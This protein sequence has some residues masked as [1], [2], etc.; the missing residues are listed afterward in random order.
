MQ[1][2][3]DHIDPDTPALRLVG[4]S[5]D[6]DA[7]AELFLG[8]EGHSLK[9]NRNPRPDAAM[10]PDS[11]I[12]DRPEVVVRPLTASTNPPASP[13]HGPPTA[14]THPKAEAETAQTVSVEALILGHLPVRSV[15]WIGQYA[16]A[17]AEKLGRP[18]ALLRLG[19][20]DASLDLHGMPLGAPTPAGADT[21]EEAIERAQAV[22]R[23]WIIQVDELSESALAADDRLDAITLLTSANETAV[24]AAYRAIKG[25]VSAEDQGEPASRPGFD[26]RAGESDSPAMR[27]AI[28]GAG[29][30]E[31]GVALTRLRHACSVFLGR[32]L[33]LAATVAKVSPARGVSL[34]RG[35]AYDLPSILELLAPPSSTQLPSHAVNSVASAHAVLTAQASPHEMTGRPHASDLGDAGR[36]LAGHLPGLRAL[37]TRCPDDPAIEL[38]IDAD[39]RLNLLRRADAPDACQRMVA[40]LAWAKRHADLLA[41]AAAS[42]GTLDPARPPLGR[43]FTSEPPALRPLLDTDIRLHL[44]AQA[45]PD[46]PW[47]CVELN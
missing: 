4:V 13:P 45:T 11:Q 19:A 14:T 10:T 46:T 41:L 17:R 21:L 12:Q 40:A 20:T 24:I 34:F 39:G 1:G 29:E 5:D 28:M 9:G 44:L 8:S 38:A 22:T 16:R 18:M 26:P 35:P 23:D 6:Y 27:V 15:V 42:V 2:A 47:L 31:A 36:P 37:P 33:E 7:L 43:L 32:P 30:E 25:L 3:H